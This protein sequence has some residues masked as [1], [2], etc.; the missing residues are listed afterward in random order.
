MTQGDI[1]QRKTRSFSDCYALDRMPPLRFDC[2]TTMGETEEVEC[3]LVT[4][5]RLDGSRP[6]WFESDMGR[7]RGYILDDR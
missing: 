3:L 7:N 1:C 2:A 6:A 5:L 4:V